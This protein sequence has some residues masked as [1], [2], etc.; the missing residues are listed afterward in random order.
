MAEVL[1]ELAD[2]GKVGAVL[3]ALAGSC[4]VAATGCAP[5]ARL[6]GEGPSE[7]FFESSSV[8]I[9]HLECFFRQPRRCE[10]LSAQ[11][12]MHIVN[13]NMLLR[14][15][16]RRGAVAMTAELVLLAVEREHESRRQRTSRSASP[17]R[18]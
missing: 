10:K 4:V 18:R 15:A 6:K 16:V 8:L 1:A 13:G 17:C 14:S 11:L 9:F 12:L 3:R 2:E 5:S 7:W